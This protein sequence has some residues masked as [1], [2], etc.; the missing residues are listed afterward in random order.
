MRCTQC[1]YCSGASLADHPPLGLHFIYYCE[2]EDMSGT[3]I[4][5]CGPGLIVIR[6]KEAGENTNTLSIFDKPYCEYY[7]E[8]M[9]GTRL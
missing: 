4:H 8:N 6:R 9:D 7:E 2:Q 1:K 5:D 3:I